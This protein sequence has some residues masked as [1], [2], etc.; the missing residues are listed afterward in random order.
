VRVAALRRC[1]REKVERL[2]FVI[3]FNR[4]RRAPG[5]RIWSAL[6]PF[7]PMA[8]A[9]LSERFIQVSRCPFG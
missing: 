1:K 5:A 4:R 7:A 6:H 3:A 8:A 2:L 9:A